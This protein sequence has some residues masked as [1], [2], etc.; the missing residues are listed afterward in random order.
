[1]YK[2]LND[3]QKAMLPVSII[4][5]WKVDRMGLLE[6]SYMKLNAS[7]LWWS[8][9][10][11]HLHHTLSNMTFIFRTPAAWPELH[12]WSTQRGLRPSV[13]KTCRETAEY[14]GLEQHHFRVLF[15]FTQVIHHLIP[16][17]VL[18]SMK[19]TLERMPKGQPM[20]QGPLRTCSKCPND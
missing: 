19:I 3:Q 7:N 14:P 18:K 6:N 9:L 20:L 10:F 1:V 16:R 11:T 2:Q 15:L 4:T 17:I 12:S 5:E 13:H 8:C